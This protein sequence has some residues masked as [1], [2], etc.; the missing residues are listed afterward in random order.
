MDSYFNYLHKTGKLAKINHTDYKFDGYELVCFESVSDN[1]NEYYIIGLNPSI[2]GAT[3][4]YTNSELLISLINLASS[5]IDNLG[6]ESEVSCYKK[7][8]EW[9]NEFGLP[10]SEDEFNEK[11]HKKYK[12]KGGLYLGFRIWEFKRS[13]KQLHDQFHLWMGLDSDDKE[14]ILKYLKITHIPFYSKNQ[15]LSSQKSISL[16]KEKL[17]KRVNSEFSIKGVGF[18]FNYNTVSNTFEMYPYSSNLIAIAYFQFS[19][20]MVNDSDL[21]VKFCNKCNNLF[22]YEHG[23]ERRCKRC[24]MDRNKD[25]VNNHRARVTKIKDKFKSGSSISQLAN[26]FKKTESDI[27]K[28]IEKGK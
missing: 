28:W 22:V 27:K 21:G 4:N 5:I 18:R 19:L 20:L 15:D 1:T 6:F 24:K 9:C 16:I 3:I 2:S 8:I 11:Y 13:I 26:E 7:I 25:N 10:Y 17:A 23:N 14:K 12:L